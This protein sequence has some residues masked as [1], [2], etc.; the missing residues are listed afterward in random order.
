MAMTTRN[1]VRASRRRY[2]APN[3]SAGMS[4]DS[5]RYAHSGS[6]GWLSHVCLPVNAR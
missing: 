5:V 6:H 2:S 1:T 4:V 3:A